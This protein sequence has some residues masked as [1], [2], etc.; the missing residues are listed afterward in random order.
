M[1]L[2]EMNTLDF[3]EYM[4]KNDA[5]IIPSGAYEIWGPHLPVGADTI[6][7]EE[8]A[9]RLGDRM[10]WLVGPTVPVGDSLF[11][12]GPGAVT[13]RPDSFRDYLEDICMSL[14]K[15]GMKRFCFLNPHVGN[16]PLISQVA[17]KLKIEQ[18]ALCCLFDWWRFIQ[19]LCS[20][21]KILDSDGI[22]SHGHASEA[23]TSLFLYLRPD[24]V[25]TDR[26][27][28]TEPKKVN[29]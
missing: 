5:V 27:I 10:G 2:L 15:H 12:W 26:L 14:V 28:R 24:L 18:G 17:A 22:M 23:G 16:V 19:P 4:G 13:A 9:F 25:R 29:A 20:E 7:A 6:I 11:S 1:K 8:M 3:Q 21:E